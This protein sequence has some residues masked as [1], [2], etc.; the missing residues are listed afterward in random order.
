MFAIIYTKYSILK[1]TFSP[2]SGGTKK[3]RHNNTDVMIQGKTDQWID[4]YCLIQLK[5]KDYVTVYVIDL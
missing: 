5:E 3:V 1:P 2:A 4:Q